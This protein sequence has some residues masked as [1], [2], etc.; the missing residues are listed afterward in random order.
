MRTA[1]EIIKLGGKSHAYTCDITDSE[2]VAQ[3]AK[4]A[5][6]VDLLFNNAGIIHFDPFLE[7]PQATVSKVID[8]NVT[9]HFL[10]SVTEKLLMLRVA[11]KHN[12][13]L[14]AREKVVMLSRRKSA[15]SYSSKA[16]ITQYTT[17]SR[18]V[19]AQSV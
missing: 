5:G 7:T 16:L 18:A 12:E 8:V 6:T 10:V 11:L 4:K 13:V 2:A 19:I 9:A 15:R 3:L 14:S 17:I 1:K